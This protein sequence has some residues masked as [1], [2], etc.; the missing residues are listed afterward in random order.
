LI[1]PQRQIDT[2]D[3][4]PM[5]LDKITKL[6][7]SKNNLTSL[8]AMGNYPEIQTLNLQHNNVHPLP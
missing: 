8:G 6:D 4:L 1:L 5:R 2:F 3:K 7:L